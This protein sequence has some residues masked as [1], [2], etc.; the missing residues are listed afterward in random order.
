[1]LLSQGVGRKRNGHWQRWWWVGCSPP[2]RLTLLL[3][4]LMYEWLET[5]RERNRTAD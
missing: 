2:P 3:L 4:P 1:M 5:R